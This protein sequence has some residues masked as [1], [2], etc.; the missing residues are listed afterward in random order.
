M[1]AN[2]TRQSRALDKQIEAIYY[3]RCGGV[4]INIMDIG[5]VFAAGREAHAAG[6]DIEAAIVARVGELRQN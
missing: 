2:E 1:R 5:K 6:A 3:R 4:Q